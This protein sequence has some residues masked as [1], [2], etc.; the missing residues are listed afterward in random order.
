MN[1][2]EKKFQK[3]L[4]YQ[5]FIDH[6]FKNLISNSFVKVTNSDRYIENL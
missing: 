5:E 2:L 1:N 3:E 4:N 6:E